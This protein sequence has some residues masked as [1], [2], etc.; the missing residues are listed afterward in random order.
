MII[1]STFMVKLRE[2]MLKGRTLNGFTF[3]PIGFVRNDAEKHTVEHE[4]VHIRQ[5][6][7]LF[8]FRFKRGYQRELEAYIVSVKHGRDI[9]SAAR[10]LSIHNGGNVFKAL[11]DLQRGLQKG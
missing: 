2:R 6:F 10:A 11:Q 7:E 5:Y 8:L 9:N 4:K 1:R 3:G